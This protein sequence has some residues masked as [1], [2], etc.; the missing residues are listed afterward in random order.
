ME[1]RNLLVISN[2]PRQTT[3]LLLTVRPADTVKDHSNRKVSIQADSSPHSRHKD[4]LIRS[5]WM[6]HGHTTLW[7]LGFIKLTNCSYFRPTP[8]VM[9]NSG[10][11]DPWS[12]STPSQA[13]SDS[14][15]S[16]STLGSHTPSSP[17]SSQLQHGHGKSAAASHG[18]FATQKQ[19]FWLYIRQ[20][21]RAGRACSNGRDRRAIDPPPVVQLQITDFDPNSPED[22]EDMQDQS[23]IVHCLLRE[24]APPGGDVSVIMCEDDNSS[25][26]RA[27]KQINGSLDASPFF[28]AEDPDPSNAPPHPS[29][30][31]YYPQQMLASQAPRRN[32][33]ATFFYFADLS[34]RKAG[35]YRLEFQ[36]MRVRLDG[37][38]VTS[39]HTVLSEP[40]HVVNAK[41][42]DHVQ[43][44]T[45]LVRGLIANQAGYPLKLKQGSR[46][47]RGSP[48]E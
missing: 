23:F 20:Q 47:R 3:S 4:L 24:A 7:K 28:C 13:G 40:L 35:V 25:A 17:A 32:L 14:Y 34:I 48:E 19:R 1:V 45:P 21:P 10:A 9:A 36:L 43:P 6:D 31:L 27:E 37:R 39:L 42:F 33:P 8:N 44:S 30:Q 41:D 16:G 46:A 12:D 11:F 26:S 18:L 22:M 38:P 15:I 5:E 2:I 29:S